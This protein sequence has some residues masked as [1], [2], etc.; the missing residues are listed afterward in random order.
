M[1]AQSVRGRIVIHSRGFGFLEVASEDG[2]GTGFIAPPDLN[3]F[4]EGDTVTAR[5]DE[6]EPGRFNATS[7]ALVERTRHELFGTVVVHG[8][9]LFLKV[10][11][12]V[13]NTDW[14]L[15]G[16]DL[17][18]LVEG[19]ALVA[20]LRGASVVPRRIVPPTEA[21]LERVVVRHGIR[22]EFPTS[23]LAAA[24]AAVQ[25]KVGAR[26]DLRELPTVTIDAP[27]SR[28]LDDAL[29]ILPAPA[30]GGL[31]L[32]VSIAD[33]DA[34]VPEGS[35]LDVEARLRGTSVYLAGRV[36]PMIPE[37]LSEDT[38]SLLPGIDRL[39]LTCELRIDPE[40]KVTSV[41]VYESVIRSNARLSYEIVSAFLDRG[42]VEHVPEDVRATLR[43]L[44]TAA[45]RISM[46]RT[47]RG[48]VTHLREEA[49]I[50]LDALTREP[51][52]IDARPSTSGD[53]LVERLMVATN[54]AVGR[55]FVERGLPGLF[56]VHGQPEEDAVASLAAFAENSGFEAGFGPKL[57]PRSLAAFE[58][59]F[60]D[61]VIAPSMYTVMG[62][63][64][65]PARYTVYPS[66]HFGLAA[67]IYLHFT[68]P[69]RRYA[70]LT[71]HRIV[72]GYLAGRRDRVAGDHELEE[73][74]V[75]VNAAAYRAVKAET[76]RSRT[77]A[78]RHFASRVG[79]SFVGNIVAIKPFGL[80]VQLADTGVTGTVATDAL[81]GGPFRVDVAAQVLRGASRTFAVGEPFEVTV[82]GAN[83]EL[84]RIDLVPRGKARAPASR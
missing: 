8:K 80:V 20:E 63:V 81:P 58:A 36:I 59:Q 6:A 78:A 41:D 44:R 60:K 37:T 49:Y 27:V 54:E 67:P 75:H 9:R 16:D 48:G 50:T 46:G 77:L 17:A 83:E 66:G 57:T 23:V 74:A 30:D 52:K 56:R 33:V 61:S 25:P 43:W 22:A 19:T 29:S 7:L 18:S 13:S 51:M 62:R 84:G 12:H 65:G 26:R 45:A 79:E 2:G 70:D 39:A 14:P 24:K 3:A 47:A 69:I 11:R 10:D 1:A 64:L 15:E 35:E 53:M 76:E 40:G 82:A 32:L 28:D 5:L 72:K 21:S 55:W 42:D 34:L 31:R 38:L 71:V 73:L 4:L 68:S